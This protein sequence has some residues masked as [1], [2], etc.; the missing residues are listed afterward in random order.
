MHL[1][2]N[3]NFILLFY[4]FQFEKEKKN[5]L[6]LNCECVRMSAS[7]GCFFSQNYYYTEIHTWM[8]SLLITWHLSFLYVLLSHSLLTL[9]AKIVK[10]W[11]ELDGVDITLIFRTSSSSSS[12]LMLCLCPFMFNFLCLN[13]TFLAIF[14][15]LCVVKG[16]YIHMWWMIS[17]ISCMSRQRT[18]RI[19]M[20]RTCKCVF[21]AIQRDISRTIKRILKY[22]KIYLKH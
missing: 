11:N 5:C 7:R 1:H 22:Y 14:M 18:G 12:Y 3:N 4:S 16:Y 20:L 19:L 21:M 10:R 2:I 8:R 9:N 17:N 6:H 15:L 13:K